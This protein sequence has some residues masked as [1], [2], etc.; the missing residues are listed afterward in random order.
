M[1]NQLFKIILLSLVYISCSLCYANSASNNSCNKKDAK[2]I[3]AAVMNYIAT[4]TEIPPNEVTVID[5][6]CSASYAS[7]ILHPKKP[8]TDDAT[9][10]LHKLNHDW[11]VMLLGTSFDEKFLAQLPKAVIRN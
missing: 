4:K 7:A 5:K 8:V 1:I 3:D 9:V 10:Y 11:Q 2:K 6:R